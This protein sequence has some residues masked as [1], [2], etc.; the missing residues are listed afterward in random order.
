MIDMIA[1]RGMHAYRFIVVEFSNAANRAGRLK[2]GFVSAFLPEP[3]LSTGTASFPG[4]SRTA[5]FLHVNRTR[6]SS[7]DSV[8]S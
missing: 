7:S 8:A 1:C 3:V 4:Y 6:D 2:R 5:S